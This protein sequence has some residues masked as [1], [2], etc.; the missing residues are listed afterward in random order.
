MHRN[1]GIFRGKDV[2]THDRR[3]TRQETIMS[4]LR[5]VTDICVLSPIRAPRRPAFRA[6]PWPAATDR[7]PGR[8]RIPFSNRDFSSL[9]AVAALESPG[10]RSAAIV[11]TPSRDRYQRHSRRPAARE[12]LQGRYGVSPI[13]R[14]P[15]ATK[16][17][18]NAAPH[19]AMLTGVSRGAAVSP[20]D[21]PRNHHPPRKPRTTRLASVLQL[22]AI[23][24]QS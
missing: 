9:D 11:G 22:R 16:T 7:H 20:A 24:T 19:T 4:P 14:A 12:A 23:L 21:F 1:H 2:V 15:E 10:G 18:L 6:R 13:A 5:Q 17:F 8:R 3:P